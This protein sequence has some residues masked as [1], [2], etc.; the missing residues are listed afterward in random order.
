MSLRPDGSLAYVALAALACAP[1]WVT[2]HPPLQDLPLHLATLRLVHSFHDPAFGFDRDFVLTLDRTQYV[3]H[4]VAGSVLAYA[5]G[6]ANANRLLLSAYLGG[7][8]LAF[9]RLLRV[10]GRDERQALFVVPLLYN[11]IFGLGLLPFLLGIPL[12]VV[13]LAETLRYFA[14]PTFGR[15]LLVAFLATLL[16]FCHVVPFALLGLGVAALF[17]WRSPGR[18]LRAGI[19]YVP[20]IVLPLVWLI[21][22]DAGRQLLEL[23]GSAGQAEHVTIRQALR[24]AYDWVG[25]TFLDRSDEGLLGALAVVVAIAAFRNAGKDRPPLPRALWLL[26]AACALF[27]LLGPTAH[28]FVWP[29]SQRFAVPAVLLAVPLLGFPEGREA[30]WVTAAAGLLAVAAVGNTIIHF[31]RFERQEVGRFDEALAQMGER[32]RIA[33]LVFDSGSQIVPT[34]PFLHFVSYY[35][36]TRGGIVQFSFAGYNHWPFDYRP[37]HYPPPGS[38][39]RPRWEWSPGSVPVDELYPYFDFVLTRGPGFLPPPGTFHETWQ[40]GPWAVWA[41]D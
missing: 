35:Q 36:A 39:A 9:R 3:L 17:P 24:D 28:G 20:A 21:R 22:T 15:G 33:A 37:G 2:G 34:H 23:A 1:A 11:P 14:R 38:P 7:T 30:R 4:Y 31:R 16:F 29:L 27:Y 40:A 13:G 12:L 19:P 6:V 26:P 8:V 41:R 25:Q 32:H 5:L 18:W 10:V